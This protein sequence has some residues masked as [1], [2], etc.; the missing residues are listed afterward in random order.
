MILII[1]NLIIKFYNAF[2][3]HK[4]IGKQASIT[5]ILPTGIFGIFSQ[6]LTQLVA[7]IQEEDDS[8]NSGENSTHSGNNNSR[9]HKHTFRRY[10]TDLPHITDHNNSDEPTEVYVD[11]N[12]K[13]YETTFRRT[14]KGLQLRTIESPRKKQKPPLPARKYKHEPFKVETLQTISENKIP[15]LQPQ[16]VTPPTAYKYLGNTAPL[17]SAPHLQQQPTSFNG[18][19]YETPLHMQQS[20]PYE[21]PQPSSTQYEIPHPYPVRPIYSNNLHHLTDIRMKRLCICSSQ[22]RMKYLSLLV[23]QQIRNL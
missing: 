9:K 22:H 21:I 20:T 12:Y 5:K 2:A 6:T 16:H 15:Q 18:H 8:Q 23:H 1:T 10:S 11:T 13:H 17:P 7:Q 4:A 14:E 3:I 19:P